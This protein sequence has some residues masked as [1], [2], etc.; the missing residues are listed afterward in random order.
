MTLIKKTAKTTNTPDLGAK[1]KV[2]PVLV[3][4]ELFE[5]KMTKTAM[6]ELASKEKEVQAFEKE[7]K[8]KD[9]ED[10]KVQEEVLRYAFDLILGD[11]AFERIHAQQQDEL[12]LLETFEAV[13]DYIKENLNVYLK[14]VEKGQLQ[15]IVDAKKS[16]K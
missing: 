15:K 8:K 12:A 3:Y 11:G 5:F 2:L 1:A 14:E 10:E 16:A 4:G 7:L 13:A 9:T 6:K